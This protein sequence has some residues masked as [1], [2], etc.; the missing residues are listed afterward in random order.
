M[1]LKNCDSDV[2]RTICD[3]IFHLPVYT[4]IGDPWMPD[5]GKKQRNPLYFKVSNRSY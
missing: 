4:L 2:M 3:V 1:N 5:S